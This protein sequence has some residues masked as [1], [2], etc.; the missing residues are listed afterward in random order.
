MSEQGN[1]R[2]GY[3]SKDMNFLTVTKSKVKLPL[4][5]LF[6]MV[7]KYV[8]DQKAMTRDNISDMMNSMVNWQEWISHEK[9][10]LVE[11]YGADYVYKDPRPL[12]Q[13]GTILDEMEFHIAGLA[14]LLQQNDEGK[15]HDR[16]IM[17]ANHGIDYRKYYHLPESYKKEDFVKAQAALKECMKKNP[18]DY[19]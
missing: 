1:G 9:D 6:R 12:G 17:F 2:F 3:I 8:Y 14:W 5:V 4:P 15:L 16:K 18:E 11:K 7:L 19:N 13:K 10:K